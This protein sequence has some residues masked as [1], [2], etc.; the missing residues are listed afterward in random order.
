M[1]N[2]FGLYLI[3]SHP[4]LG[5]AAVAEAAVECGVRYLQ[6]RMKH[7][8]HA[9]ILATARRIRDI[10]RGTETR[11]IMNDDLETAMEVDAD[12]IH[13]GQ[14]DLSIGQ[15]RKRWSAEKVYG[16]STHSVRQ[17]EAAERLSPN[18]IGIGPAFSTPTKPEAGPGLGPEEIAR[19]DR[20]TGLTS[21]AIGGITAKNLPELLEAG[22]SNFCVIGAVNNSPDPKAAI[23]KLQD[24][25]QSRSF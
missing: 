12:G 22:I 21:V 23:Q 24:I 17:A 6:L 14:D 16:L 15:A 7:E 19:I 3:L 1:K 11:F 4:A 5:Y 20:R 13:L 18:Y 10:T 2:N 9:D 25:W 8:A